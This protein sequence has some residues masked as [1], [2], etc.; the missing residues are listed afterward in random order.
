MI[1]AGFAPLLDTGEQAGT[2]YV[3]GFVAPVPER[4]KEAYR[5]MAE[6]ASEVFKDHGAV[7]VVEGWG[8]DVP[9]GKVTDYYRATKAEDGEK[10]VFSWVEWPSKEA[11]DAGWEKV[12][13]DERMKQDP[14]QEKPFDGMRMFYGGFAPIFDR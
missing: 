3:D 12:M 5:A 4:N 6:M 2:G 14:D 10:V 8:D 13:A 11:R 7:R 1:V 9:H